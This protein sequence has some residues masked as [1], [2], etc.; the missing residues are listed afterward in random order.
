MSA[1][2]LQY[3][4][5]GSDRGCCGA[6]HM[7]IRAAE[8]CLIEDHRSMA[9]SGGCS[10]RKIRVVEY[11]EVAARGRFEARGPGTDIDDSVLGIHCWSEGGLGGWTLRRGGGGRW[12]PNAE[13]AKEIAAADDSDRCIRQ[14]CHVEPNR[15]KWYQ[16]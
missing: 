14:M 6:S 13:A 11:G 16:S 9:K 5:W 10:D 15:G 4:C 7:T 8:G 3:T 1:L 12:I 2:I